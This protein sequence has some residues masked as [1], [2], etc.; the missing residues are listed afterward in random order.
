MDR[1]DISSFIGGTDLAAAPIPTV[2]FNLPKEH[3]LRFEV[4][5]GETALIKL[6]EG[7]AEYFGTELLLNREYKLTGCKG[8]VFTWNSCKLEVSQSTKAYIANETPMMQYARV[9][10]IMDDIRISCLSNR[11]SGPKVIIVGPT[12]V[13]K[14]SISKI[15]LGYSTRLG[16]APTF[17]DLDPGQGSITIPGAV[18]AS[19]VDK[20]VDIEDGLTNSLPFVQYYGHTSLDANPTLFKALVSS[21]ATSIEK[22]METNEQARVSGVIINTCGWIDGLGYEIL[23]DS[24]DIFKANL[25]VVMDNDKLY[26][27]LN[28]KYTGAIKVIKLPKSGGV[29]LRSPIFRKKTRMSKIREYFY[30]ISGDLCP[31][32]TILDF[33]DIVVLKTGGGPAAPSSALPIGAQSVIDPLQLQEVT[34]STDM[35]HSILAVSYTKSKQSILKSNIAGFLYV[36]EVNLETKKMTVLAPCPGLIPSKFLL[37]GTLKW[38]E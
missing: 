31:H 29:Y 38:L 20:P 26:S 34:P 25:I 22:R 18:C 15:L 5:H 23:I 7:N 19:L 21:L 2:I 9:H 16:Y 36:T 1:Q 37:M 33:K 35:I 24:I 14:S 28:K 11:E 12:D 8:A 10:K 17:V 6:I 32:F 27:E 3:E 13:G 30:G 4:E